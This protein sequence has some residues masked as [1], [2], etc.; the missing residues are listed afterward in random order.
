MKIAIFLPNWIGDVVMATPALRTIRD[1]FPTAEIVGVMRPYVTDVLAGT[2]LIDRCLF[3]DP[4]GDSPQRRGWRFAR[5]LRSENLDAAVLL[6]NSL[7][8]AWMARLS[9]AKTRI[10]FDR[11]CRGWLLTDPVR[12]KPKSQPHPALEEY[13]RLAERLGWRHLTRITELATLPADEHALSEFWRDHKA[14]GL[15]PG[16]PRSAG[17]QPRGVGAHTKYICLNPG[18]AFGAA[19]HW[20]SESFGQL[21]QRLVDELGKTVLVLCG[22]AERD[23]AREIARIANRPE[24]VVTLADTQPSIGLTKAA[25][26]HS[27]LL[28]TTDSGPRHFAQPFGVPVVTLFGPTHIAWSETSY[29][30]AVHLQLDVDCGPCQKR[31]CPFGHHKCMRDLTV[32]TVFNAAA[33]SLGQD[34]TKRKAA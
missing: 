8:S 26:K 31:V 7:R 10:G 21:A 24:R 22:P 17:T 2:N 34:T 30:H 32:E 5:Q 4:R 25:V 1:E 29:S 18:G 19:K 16:G 6:P 33:N 15:H 14:A 28:I 12:P 13:L 20:P 27:E 9:G 23:T 3:H 11:N